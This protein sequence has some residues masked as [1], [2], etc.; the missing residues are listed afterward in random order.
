VGDDRLAVRW[1]ETRTQRELDLYPSIYRIASEIL[2]EAYSRNVITPGVTTTTDVEY[3]IMQRIDDMGLSAWFASDV[4]VQR[5]GTPGR[6]T[7]VVIREGDLIHT[8]YGL[9]YL[10]LCTDSQRLGYL[11]REGETQIP[12][13]LL[14]GLAVG[15]R[16]QDIV[17]E[18]MLPGRSGNEIFAHAVRR[19]KAEGIR[20]SL[21]TH[22]IGVYGHA[23]GPTIG[24]WDQQGDV[25]GAG[26]M[27]HHENTCYA[28]ELNVT[29]TVPEWNAQD[30]GFYI[31]ETVACTKD[32][33]SFLDD[34]RDHMIVI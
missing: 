22:P 18:E 11:L 7:E 26:E 4:D 9:E 6:L 24:L 23:A 5:C 14:R 29:E 8:D 15:N 25:P 21:Y 30:V 32:S 2:R 3:Y 33:V 17:R 20:P 13:G 1:M 27:V 10:G 31:E 16:F 28:L 12:Q 19:A 34:F